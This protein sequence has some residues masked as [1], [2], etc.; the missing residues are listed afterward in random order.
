M[1]VFS[2]HICS[3]AGAASSLSLFGVFHFRWSCHGSSSLGCEKPRVRVPGP[4]LK[5]SSRHA[6][7]EAS[8]TLDKGTEPYDHG[9]RILQ[10]AEDPPAV[11][12]TGAGRNTLRALLLAGSVREGTERQVGQAPDAQRA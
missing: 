11:A 12:C 2:E 6:S 3:T 4:F 7:G 5:W 9:P 10:E 1:Q 8:L